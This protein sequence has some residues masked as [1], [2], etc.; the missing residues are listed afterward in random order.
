MLTGVNK[1]DRNAMNL[2]QP[3]MS[4]TGKN[5]HDFFSFLIYSFATPPKYSCAAI[6][7][8]SITSAVFEKLPQVSQDLLV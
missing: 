5:V 2:S 7:E 3:K 6:L 1:I 4:L 8:A